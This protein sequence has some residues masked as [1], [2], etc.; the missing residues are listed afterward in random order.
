MYQ[1]ANVSIGLSA[2]I[3]TLSIIIYKFIIQDSLLI[4]INNIHSHIRLK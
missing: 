3:E 4:N 1:C 2:K